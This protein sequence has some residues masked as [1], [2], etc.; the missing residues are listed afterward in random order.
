[1]KGKDLSDETEE[2]TTGLAWSLLRAPEGPHANRRRYLDLMKLSLSD[3]LYENDPQNRRKAVEGW[4]WPSRA[5][6]MIGLRR[7]NNI[8][9]CV[10]HIP[11][12]LQHCPHRVRTIDRGC[13]DR[14]GF[15][16]ERA[17]FR[18]YTWPL[19]QP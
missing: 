10:E 2:S 18:I 4:G 3:L 9:A 1:M 5:C 14:G 17:S 15:T 8:E 16:L 11:Q 19:R 12:H 7:L 6:T 13:R